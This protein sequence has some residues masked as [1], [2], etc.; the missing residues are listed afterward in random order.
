MLLQGPHAPRPHP[1]APQ[2]VVD[3][4]QSFLAKLQSTGSASNPPSKPKD[5]SLEDSKQ[6]KVVQSG[7]GSQPSSGGSSAA[8]SSGGG[9]SG[10]VDFEEWWK[11]PTRL[12]T[13][14]PLEP[15]EIEAIE[16]S[17]RQ[18]DWKALYQITSDA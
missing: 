14:K 4:F 18:H 5:Q 13:T 12:T 1:A 3:S 10:A 2:E 16:V 8:K 15:A 6:G 9:G 7:P 17:T 11:A